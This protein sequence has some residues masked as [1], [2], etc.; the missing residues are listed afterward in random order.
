M[1][2][3]NEYRELLKDNEVVEDWSPQE[4]DAAI[5]KGYLLYYWAIYTNTEEDRRKAA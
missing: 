5:D 3:I 4:M 1:G 2:I